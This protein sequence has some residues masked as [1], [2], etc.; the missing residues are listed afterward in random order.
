MRAAADAAAMQ[1]MDT[2]TREGGMCMGGAVLSQ[3]NAQAE[4]AAAERGDRG[5]E[6]W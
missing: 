2:G 6:R 3:T 5:A 1:R 4:G